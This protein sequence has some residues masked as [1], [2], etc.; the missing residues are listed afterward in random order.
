M[1]LYRWRE[2]R[3]CAPLPGNGRSCELLC[4]EGLRHGGELLTRKTPRDLSRSGF[5]KGNS[6]FTPLFNNKFGEDLDRQCEGAKR[7]KLSPA[8]GAEDEE[9]VRAQI[10]ESTVSFLREAREV[11]ARYLTSE[12][13]DAP[14]TADGWRD[15]AVRR[16]GEL[17]GGGPRAAGRDWGAFVTSRLSKPPPPSPE[18]L[19]QEF[20]A[21]DMWQLLCCC[22]LMSRVSSWETKHRCISAFFAEYPTP[23]A[24]MARV[25]TQGETARLRELVNSLGLYDDRL[26]SLTAI[27]T[28]FLLPE[29]GDEFAVDLKEHKIRGIGVSCGGGSNPAGPRSAHAGSAA[30]FL[31]PPTH[32]PTAARSVRRDRSL[33][34]TRGSSSAATSAP[35]SGRQTSASAATAAG[36]RSS[37]S[38]STGRGRVTA[39]RSTDSRGQSATGVVCP[40]LTGIYRVR[41]SAV[42]GRYSTSRTV[43]RGG[44]LGRR[45]GRDL[46]SSIVVLDSNVANW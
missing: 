22:V 33:G 16:W 30:A 17:A 5:T 41:C 6:V 40:S 20:Y 29:G 31:Q 46:P 18:P 3:Y 36:A 25:V 11:M 39:S 23:S 24:F 9:E 13:G 34:G 45:G 26:K 35:R 37:S 43:T 21:A 27:A 4:G 42:R 1:R 38:P 7:R 28:A 10:A 8:E 15:E 44:R 19:L 2:R 32:P 14:L 12:D